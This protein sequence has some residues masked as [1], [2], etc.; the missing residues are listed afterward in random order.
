MEFVEGEGVI[1]WEGFVIV[2]DESPPG[3]VME[4]ATNPEAVENSFVCK[5]NPDRV[6]DRFGGEVDLMVVVA[7]VVVAVV[8]GTVLKGSLPLV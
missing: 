4:G 5:F 3:E 6:E 7:M 1:G 8:G 2:N